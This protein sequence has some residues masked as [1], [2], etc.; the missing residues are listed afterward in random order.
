[1]NFRGNINWEDLESLVK[2][3]ADRVR[4]KHPEFRVFGIE[5]YGECLAGSDAKHT[6]KTL[7]SFDDCYSGVGKPNT[8]FIYEFNES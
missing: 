6:Y 1:M 8:L 7:E 4:Q 5:N 2:A 3:C